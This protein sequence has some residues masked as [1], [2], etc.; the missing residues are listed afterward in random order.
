MKCG[1]VVVGAGSGTRLKMDRQKAFVPLGQAP[2]FLHSLKTFQKHSGIDEIVLVLP[3]ER[4]DR[5]SEKGVAPLP[6]RGQ[7]AHPVGS[8]GGGVKVVAG[9]NTRQESVYNGLSSLSKECEAVLVHDA[10]R[11]FVTAA[12][13]NRLLEKV[14]KGIGC[15]AAWPVSDTIKEVREGI[16]V[17]TVDRGALM[18]AQ[19]PQAFPVAVLKEALTKAKTDGFTGTDEASL[20]ERL[21]LVV[22]VVL[23][24]PFNI[25]ITTPEDLKLAEALLR[26]QK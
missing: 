15:M 6:V 26:S 13:I 16:V 5:V 7:N 10:A 18:A 3:P 19:T 1:V 11:P 12:V 23:G 20:V 2:L 21:G 25:K 9:G 24:D 14:S 22:E 8:T 4:I 17:K